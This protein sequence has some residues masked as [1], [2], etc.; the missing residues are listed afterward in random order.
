M[1][2]LKELVDTETEGNQRRRRPHPG[3]HG[4]LVGDPGA[5]KGQSGGDVEFWHVHCGMTC[6]PS[7][8]SSQGVLLLHSEIAGYSTVQACSVTPC[9]SSIFRSLTFRIVQFCPFAGIP[10]CEGLRGGRSQH[11]VAAL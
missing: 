5:L 1:L 8:D 11:I 6:H 4:T 10:A 9:D 7:R 2:E 3:H